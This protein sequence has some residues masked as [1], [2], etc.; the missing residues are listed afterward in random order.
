MTTHSRTAQ[1]PTVGIIYPGHA[2]EDDYPAFESSLKHHHDD[3]G[4]VRLPVVISTIGV[5]EHT[6]AALLETGSHARLSEATQRLQAEHQV[7][8]IMWACT[9][10]SFVYGWDGAHRQ[11]ERLAEEAGLPASSTSLA[12]A[13]ALEALRISTVAVAASYP[14]ELA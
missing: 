2:A 14:A 3:A 11:A 6:A 1:S 13:R 9:S 12:F 4:S 7:D 5:D 8:S 10:G